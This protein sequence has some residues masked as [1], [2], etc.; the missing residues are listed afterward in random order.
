MADGIPRLIEDLAGQ[1]RPR[2][3]PQ[4]EALGVEAGPGHDCGGIL[5]VLIISGGDKSAFRSLQRELARLELREFKMPILRSDRPCGVRAVA[6]I[7]D[8]NAGFPDRRPV[9]CVYDRARD[10]KLCIMRVALLGV[11]CAESSAAGQQ[12]KHQREGSQSNRS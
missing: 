6:G 9:E 4:N 11:L 10:S 3:E 8:R 7:E 5:F 2:R 12:E 1:Q